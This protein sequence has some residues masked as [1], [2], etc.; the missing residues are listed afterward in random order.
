MS[1]GLTA[2]TVFHVGI[3]LAGIISGFVVAIGLLTNK[4]LDG[5]TA[6]F[7]TTTV[8]TSVTGFFFPVHHFMPSHGVG[9]ISLLVLPIAI[10]ARYGRHLLG[11]WQW[12]YVVSAM[13]AL[14]LNVF[15][16]VVQAFLKVPALKAVAPTQSEAP[17]KI[18]QLTV[19]VGFVILTVAALVRSR[20]GLGKL[21]SPPLQPV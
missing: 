16:L 5:W 21:A 13:F 12:V 2:F 8:A 1:F 6:I 9:I 20:A 18:A 10:F 11:P 17:F 15:V 7:L 3:S 14:Y 19:L 4:R